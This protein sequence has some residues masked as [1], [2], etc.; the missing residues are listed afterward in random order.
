[1]ATHGI[2]HVLVTDAEGKLTG[3]VSERDL[4]ALHRIG[5]RQIRQAI[6]SAA[7]VEALLRSAADVRQLSF[8]ML[9]Q[10][11]GAEQL[12]QFISALND[13]LTHRLFDLLLP[14]F[15]I[16]DLD[17]CWLS[18]G[19]EGRRE[20]TVA[21]DQDNA[22]IFLGATGASPA[23]RERLLAFARAANEGLAE[24]EFPLC[25]G[26]IMASN[27]EHCLDTVEWRERFAGW[28]REPTPAALLGAN[29]FF[30]FRARAGRWCS[31]WQRP[32][33]RSPPER[34]SA[35]QK[36]SACRGIPA[37]PRSTPHLQR[38]RGRCLVW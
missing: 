20:Q 11:I 18:V 26:N 5:L 28:I 29:I 22:M 32:G 34:Q 4:F 19:S 27:P 13:A 24:L 37:W 9:A 15:D 36:A 17:W 23:I 30:D 35:R 31:Q 2:R 14:R 8:N 3:V 38:A 16:D 25:P 33:G 21:T 7:D 6:E 1:M 12:T 10:G